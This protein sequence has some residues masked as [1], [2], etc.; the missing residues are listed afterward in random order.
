MIGLALL[1]STIFAPYLWGPPISI[2]HG[3]AYWALDDSHVDWL[4]QFPDFPSNLWKR[5]DELK[6]EL[7]TKQDCPPDFDISNIFNG[8]GNN[9]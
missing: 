4:N 3:L 6:K 1:P 5:K 2:P 7:L 9:D 8:N